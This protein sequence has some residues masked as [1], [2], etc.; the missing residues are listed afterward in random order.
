MVIEVFRHGNIF[1][2]YYQLT[3]IF[4]NF[5]I[6]ARTSFNNNLDPHNFS[7]FEIG[8]LTPPGMVNK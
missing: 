1:F 4:I 6:G 7:Q 3:Q 8:E 5:L 2:I